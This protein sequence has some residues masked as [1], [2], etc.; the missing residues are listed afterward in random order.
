MNVG[1]K[2]KERFWLLGLI[3]TLA[4]VVSGS[5]YA[6]QGITQNLEDSFELHGYVENQEIIRNENYVKGYNMA[7]IRNRIDLQP[8]GQII[9][10]ASLPTV[11]GV[12]LGSGLSVNYFADVRF[13]YEAR[14]RYRYRPLRKSHHRLVGLGLFSICYFGRRREYR[15]V[16]RGFRLQTLSASKH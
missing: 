5:A 3:A 12:P 10:D 14:L 11:A 16:S 7:S 6:Q 2:S 13:G 1:G 9:K 8:S 15:L 4:L